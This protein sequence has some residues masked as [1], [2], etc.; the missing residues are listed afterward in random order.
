MP[1][2]AGETSSPN[3]DELVQI[4]V[5]AGA[6]HHHYQPVRTLRKTGDRLSLYP[7]YGMVG[8]AHALEVSYPPP[9]FGED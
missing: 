4:M 7:A 6:R 2:A 9:E 3:D 5:V 1:K 8:P